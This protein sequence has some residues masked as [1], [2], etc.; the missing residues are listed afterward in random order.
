MT[1]VNPGYLIA[2]HSEVKVIAAVLRGKMGTS[3]LRNVEMS[4][5]PCF[6]QTNRGNFELTR[7]LKPAEQKST[8]LIVCNPF[9]T[10]PCYSK[11]I[12]GW[13]EQAN[14]GGG[15][16]QKAAEG[17]LRDPHYGPLRI[18]E[19]SFALLPSLRHSG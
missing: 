13:E 15:V 9:R 14:L 12:V 2:A 5:W 8:D 18:K 4:A 11:R 6:V 16:G 17:T 10:V 19:R 1:S 7:A 3:G